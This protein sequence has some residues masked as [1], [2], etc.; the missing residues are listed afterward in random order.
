MTSLDTRPLLTLE[1]VDHA[2]QQLAHYQ[3]LVKEH[4]SPLLVFDA[5]VLRNKFDC[6]QKALPGVELYY[7]VKAHPDS[8]IVSVIDSLGGGFD[9]ASAGEMDLLMQHKISGRRTIHTHPIKK[10]QEI[11]DALRFGATTFVVDNLY[12]LKKLVDYRSRVGVLLRLSFRSES[13]KVDLSKKFGCSPDEV[14]ELV[15]AAEKLGIHIKGLS[16]HVGSQVE[17]AA[18]HVEA[19][20]ACRAL[21]EQINLSADKPLSVLD[22]GGGFPADYA[23]EGFDIKAFCAPIREAL[24]TLPNDWHIIAEPGRYLIAPAVTSITTV[25]GKSHRNGF[26]WYYLDDGI[27]GSYSGQLFD[28]AVY[29]LQVFRG[30]EKKASI[31]AGPTCDSIDVIAENILMPD[32]EIGDLIVGHQMGAYTAAT[33]TR[34]NSLPDAKL[35]VENL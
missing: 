18:K 2:E 11:R 5:N 17:D 8:H 30:G 32:L 1:S 20:H 22:I 6:L 12:E 23:L 31:I 24:S 3:Q 29:P 9:I 4:G 15:S 27:Y 25:A 10:D 35:I 19:V 34:F 33:K 26:V 28:H 13:A 16:F 21:M 14:I 7:A